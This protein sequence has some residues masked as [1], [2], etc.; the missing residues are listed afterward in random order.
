MQCTLPIEEKREVVICV[1]G[2]QSQRDKL[3]MEYT[4]AVLRNKAKPILTDNGKRLTDAECLH[5][6]KDIAERLN[7][8]ATEDGHYVLVQQYEA[9]IALMKATRER[10]LALLEKVK[11]ALNE[12]RVKVSQAAVEANGEDWMRERKAA[13]RAFKIQDPA[14]NEDLD[15]TAITQRLIE[16]TFINKNL[17]TDEMLRVLLQYRQLDPK[18]YNKQLKPEQVSAMQS[19][20]ARKLNGYIH[21]ARNRNNLKPQELASKLLLWVVNAKP[22]KGNARRIKAGGLFSCRR[23][24]QQLSNSA[25]IP[26]AV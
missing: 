9:T 14:T 2:N 24:V 20:I 23:D 8:S 4:Q 6:L 19:D 22:E 3:T 21:D 12:E 1:N 11:E 5:K 26:Q 15:I 16:M 7:L 18:Y 25:P 10:E 13:Q 17:S